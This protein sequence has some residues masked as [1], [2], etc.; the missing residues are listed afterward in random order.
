MGLAVPLLTF[1]RGSNPFKQVILVS[2]RVH[3][4]ETNSSF[5][6]KGLLRWLAE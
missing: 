5:M 6:C 3:P 4:G 1:T 2:C